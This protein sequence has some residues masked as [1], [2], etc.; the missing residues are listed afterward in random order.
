MEQSIRECF[1]LN[2]RD[3][4]QY[5]SLSLAFLGDSVY[6]MI[7]RTIL[8]EHYMEKPGHLNSHKKRWVQAGAQAKLVTWLKDNEKLTEDELA[9]YRRGRNA[10]IGSMAK[11]A[12]MQEYRKATGFEALV[13]YLY[14]Q[15]EMQRLLT[16]IREGAESIGVLTTEN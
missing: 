7:V 3:V 5:S 4:R 13:G 10:N 9:V 8:V 12:T 11:N 1:E 2:E 6:E 14:L 16:L 15:G